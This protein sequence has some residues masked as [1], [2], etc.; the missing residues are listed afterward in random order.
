MVRDVVDA[1]PMRAGELEQALSL[2]TKPDGPSVLAFTGV[3]GAGKSYL[4]KAIAKR[5]ARLPKTVVVR[6]PLSPIDGMQPVDLL[7]RLRRL[8]S[9]TAAVHG[10]KLRLFA[11]DLAVCRYVRKTKGEADATSLEETLAR[12]SD[13]AFKLLMG[14]ARAA[15]SLSLGALDAEIRAA[16]LASYRHLDRR[17]GL[18][19]ASRQVLEAHDEI[20]DT[21]KGLSAGRISKEEMQARLDRIFAQGNPAEEFRKTQAQFAKRLE[22]LQ[23]SLRESE[24]LLRKMQQDAEDEP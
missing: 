16:V 23:A 7:L 14:A 9:E 24:Q 12:H 1:E 8:A 18:L 19:G 2:L 5:A 13:P 15:G 22:D 3:E 11:F 10:R 6:L 17:R 20:V 4:L 21:F